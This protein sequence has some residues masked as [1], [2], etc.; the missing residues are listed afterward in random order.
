MATG[1]V[2][3]HSWNDGAE[4]DE[5]EPSMGANYDSRLGLRGDFN[6][7]I[8]AGNRNREQGRGL[9][10]TVVRPQRLGMDEDEENGAAGW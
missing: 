7:P 2:T 4:D 10:S 1:T 6:P 3:V 8:R 5:G 9:R